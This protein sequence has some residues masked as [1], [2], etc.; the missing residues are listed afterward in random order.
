MAKDT[1]KTIGILESRKAQIRKL[2]EVY[3][4]ADV[5]VLEYLLQGKIDLKE[6]K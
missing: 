2:G 3:G 6:L 4:Y 1:I 5:T